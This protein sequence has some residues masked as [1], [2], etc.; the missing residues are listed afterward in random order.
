MEKMISPRFF[1]PNYTG[2]FND[3]RLERRGAEL[4]SRLSLH[5]SSSIRQLAVNA[6]QQKAFYRFLENDKITEEIL[7]EEI[8]SRMSSLATA[9]HLLCLQDTC[10]TN[11]CKHKG[12]LK[13]NSGLGRSDKSDTAHCFKIHPGMVLDAETLTPLGFSHIKIY[14]RP[15]EM[16]KGAE[17]KY[18]QQPIEEKESYKWIEVAQKSKNTLEQATSI[19]F[20]QDREGDIYELFAQVADEAKNHHLLVRSRTTRNLINGKNLYTEVDAAP[21]AGTYSIELPTDNR[22]KQFKRIAEIELRFTTCSIKRPQNLNKTYPEF[23]T[24]SCIS[25]KETGGGAN[26][27][28]WKLLTTHEV[29]NYKDALKMVEWYGVRWY[30]EQL[31]R[32]LKKQGFGIEETELESGWG[33]RKLILMQMTALLKV[34]QMNIAYAQPEEGQLIEEVFDQQQI[35]VLKLM[36][37][38]LQGEGIKLKNQHNPKKLKWAAWVIGRLGGWKGYDSQGP[39]G[40]IALKMGLDRLGYIIEGINLEKDVGTL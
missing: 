34:L 4:V 24:I 25:V 13:P 33:I 11:F 29:E 31:F 23:I 22:K 5:P 32:L 20:I 16:P 36:N 7:I 19:T 21:V 6:A 9:K 17:R 39:P 27:I 12:R 38:K 1:S 2:R 3:T 26:G 10:E 30:V 40:V 35:R 14:H 8:S 37:I 18:K 28:S 15:E